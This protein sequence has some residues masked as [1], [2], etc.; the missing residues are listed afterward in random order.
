MLR[1]I[2]S[3]LI[4][5]CLTS[6]LYSQSKKEKKAIKTW[7]IKSIT[8]MVTENVNGKET[9]RKDSYSIFDKNGNNTYSE[10]YK[11]DGSLKHK[12]TNKFD[13]KGNKLEEIVFD[14]ADNGSEKNYKKTYKYDSEENR[15]EESEFDETGKL[16]KK[17]QFAYNASGEKVS[18]A[19]FNGAGKVVKKTV[20]A[21][22]SK[23]LKAVKKE[24]DTNDKV[25][26]TRTYQYEF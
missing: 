25:I 15:I 4:V 9:N 8:E 16:L 24:F 6:S 5:I 12:E 13:S 1:V 11:K 10:E 20:Y 2:I 23:G 3:V 26:S 7:G 21:Y 17:I 14:A 19:E 18:E 22:D